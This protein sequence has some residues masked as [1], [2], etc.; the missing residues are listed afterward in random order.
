[1]IVL[2]RTGRGPLEPAMVA[3]RMDEPCAAVLSLPP[4]PSHRAATPDR[5]RLFTWQLGR[6]RGASRMT[7]VHVIINA[8]R[9]AR[10]A[11]AAHAAHAGRAKRGG[12]ASLATL[13]LFAT[14]FIRQSL[15]IAEETIGSVTQVYDG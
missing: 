1:R 7:H 8:A 15:A 14:M 6:E 4:P 12:I 9:A 11:R 13:L 3:P 2:F 5:P 10:A